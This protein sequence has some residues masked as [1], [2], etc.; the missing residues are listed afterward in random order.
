MSPG[1]LAYLGRERLWPGH[2]LHWAG[3]DQPAF[4]LAGTVAT[5]GLLWEAWSP[6]GMAWSL[7]PRLFAEACGPGGRW[8]LHS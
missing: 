2:C 7:G 8:G 5:T 4:G 1:D 6:K 3:W